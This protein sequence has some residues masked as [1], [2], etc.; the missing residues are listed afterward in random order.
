[1]KRLSRHDDRPGYARGLI[2]LM[3]LVAA[4]DEYIHMETAHSAEWWEAFARQVTAEAPI[5][6]AIPDVRNP[7]G[8][9]AD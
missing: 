8:P 2:F 4:V 6:R 7:L 3:D 1:M 9:V 5:A